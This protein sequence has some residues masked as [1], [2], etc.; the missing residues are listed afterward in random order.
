MGLYV[1]GNLPQED[2]A[3]AAVIGARNCTAYGREAANYMARELAAAG[4]QIISGMALGIDGAG[5]E[6]ALNGVQ[7]TQ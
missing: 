2:K 5:H 3:T 6:G 1:K 7:K 4:I